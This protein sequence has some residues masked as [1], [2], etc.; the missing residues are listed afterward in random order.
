[1][2]RREVG[3][4]KQA[5][6]MKGNKKLQLQRDHQLRSRTPKNNVTEMLL[7]SSPFLE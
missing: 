5:Y 6:E 3:K 7:G 2:H 1:M 4:C